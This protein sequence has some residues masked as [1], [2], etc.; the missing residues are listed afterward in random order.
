MA[1][2]TRAEKES[3]AKSKWLSS[4]SREEKVALAQQKWESENAPK[5]PSTAEQV[6][7]AARGGLSSATLGLSEPA[8]SALNALLGAGI[9]RLP[10][11]PSDEELGVN[12]VEAPKSSLA[13]LYSKD[14]ARREGL[15]Q[16]AP[17]AELAGSIAG[18]ISPVGPAAA[19]FKAAQ[20]LGKGVAGGLGKIPA[21]A[22]GAALAGG[23]S[24]AIE[25][26]VKGAAGLD[27]SREPG[28]MEAGKTAGIMSGAIESLPGV[29]RALKGVGRAAFASTFGVKGSTVTQFLQNA[30]LV[31]NA[32][33]NEELF[34]LARNAVDSVKESARANQLDM[35][36]EI[37]LGLGSLKA[38]VIQESNV[39][40]QALEDSGARFS[41][42]EIKKAIKSA[43]APIERP[44]V[45]GPAADQA[46]QKVENFIK[47]IDLLPDEFDGLTLKNIIKSIDDNVEF[48]QTPGTFSKSSTQRILLDSRRKLDDIIK[49]RVPSYEEQMKGVSKL[50][51]LLDKSSELVGGEGKAYNALTKL[52]KPDR[53]V[54]NKVLDSF[55]KEAKI[56]PERFRQAQE[57]S[58]LFQSWNA[59]QSVENKIKALMSNKSSTVR[60]QWEALS[61][62]SDV[63]F[64]KQI[65][66]TQI[67]NQFEQEFLRGSR[68]VNL[69]TIIGAASGAGIDGGFLGGAG[70]AA[71]GA[72]IDKHGPKMARKILEGVA[73]I[74]GLPTVKKIAELELP[75]QVKTELKD[76]FIR[77]VV[78]GKQSDSPVKI[79]A[80]QKDFVIKEVEASSLSP[81]EKAKKITRLNK[82]GEI[83]GLRG[84]VMGGEKVKLSPDPVDYKKE[85]NKAV[86]LKGV[87]DFVEK[88]KVEQY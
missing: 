60:G 48:L 35:A 59:D 34:A 55:F 46:K 78:Q 52:G 44:G 26:G 5:G 85:P 75:D 70:G 33:S 27:V 57:N 23:G 7:T 68:N 37:Q 19:G 11:G 6:E 43:T 54:E 28:A 16:A 24:Q 77:S 1:D 39:A 79:G 45:I 71:I 84:L 80:D 14:I 62:L 64:I 53:P 42:E 76:S 58:K 72:L 12:T 10:V 81:I 4:L 15:K 18:A 56:D 31:K 13:D 83:E 9:E 86:T 50:A 40:L 20:A 17:G 67:A 47:D 65:E 61:K 41:K 32:K 82:T 36:D 25:S 51:Q 8:I 38:K 87:S 22:I 29:G 88:R 30:D 3:A 73:A 2:M 63:D 74:Q 66:A 69:W 49:T 21:A